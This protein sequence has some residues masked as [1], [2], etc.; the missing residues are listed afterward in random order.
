[1]ICREGETE[2]SIRGMKTII[3]AMGARS[4]DVLSAQ[5]KVKV[6]EVYV[7]GDAKKPRKALEAIAEGAE[8]ARKI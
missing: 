5:L 7:I 4:V 8:I 3:L 6:P 1:V 2:E